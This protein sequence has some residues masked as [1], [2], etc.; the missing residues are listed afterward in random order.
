MAVEAKRGCGYRKIGGIYLVSG[1]GGIACDRLPIAL[2]VC[3]VCSHGFKQ[4]RGWTW[5]DVAGLTGGVHQG[6]TDEFPCPLCMDTAKMGKAGMIWIGE[7]FYKTPAD[8]DKEGV[9]LGFSRRIKAVPRG[10]KIGV[11]WV[12]LA[13]PLTIPVPNCAD[14]TC[15]HPTNAHGP[16]G[17][18]WDVNCECEAHPP[19]HLPGIFKVWRPERI[20]KILPDTM[21]KCVVVHGEDSQIVADAAAAAGAVAAL[22]VKG[23]KAEWHYLDEEVEKLAE[24]GITPVFVPA[25][26]PDHRGSIWDSVEERDGNDE[27]GEEEEIP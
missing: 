16:Q 8:F 4:S 18:R 22:K 17:C 12:L 26:D 23:E 10:F 19:T 7:R 25:N 21:Q 13:H 27:R 5:I 15:G 2:T 20:E 9:Q 3:P 6:C 24:Q 1:G 11:T 14:P